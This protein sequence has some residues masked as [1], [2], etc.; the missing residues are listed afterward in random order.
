MTLLPAATDVG[1]AEFVTVMSDCVAPATISAAVALL[2]AVFGSAVAELTLTVS[3]IGVPAAVPAVTV[4]LKVIVA[5]PGAKLGSVQVSAASGV[6]FHPAGPASE[7]AVVCAGS[8]SV[9]VTAV[10]VLGPALVTT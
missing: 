9:R 7:T 1:E 2:F 10:A 6:Q 3:L 4:T 8:I 5:V